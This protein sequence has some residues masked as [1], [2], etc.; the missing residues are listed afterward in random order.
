MPRLNDIHHTIVVDRDLFM[1]MYC[2]LRTVP[3][4]YGFF[5][6]KGRL[7]REMIAGVIVVVTR[8]CHPDFA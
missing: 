7:T 1:L 4:W 5:M 8:V 6:V 2:L 3:S